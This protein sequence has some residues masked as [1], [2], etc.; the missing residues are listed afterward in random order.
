M[1][2]NDSLYTWVLTHG[3]DVGGTPEPPYY[4]DPV[5]KPPQVFRVQHLVIDIFQFIFLAW[6]GITR[7]VSANVQASVCDGSTASDTQESVTALQWVNGSEA[8]VQ[9]M[10]PLTA[11]AANPAC[12]C[13][14]LARAD[15]RSW[16]GDTPSGKVLDAS[17]SVF[18]TAVPGFRQYGPVAATASVDESLDFTGWVVGAILHIHIELDIG[19]KIVFH[20][21]GP[22]IQILWVA[23][24]TVVTLEDL[25][26]LRISGTDTPIIEF[27]SNPLLGLDDAAIQTLI[28]AQFQHDGDL[29]WLGGTIDITAIE[30]PIDVENFTIDSSLS[31][32]ASAECAL[33]VPGDYTY[34]GHVDGID[35]EHFQA[36]VTGPAMPQGDPNCANA[37]FN[38][39]GCVDQRDFA[40][41][42]RCFSGSVRLGDPDCLIGDP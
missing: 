9:D 31:A 11:T 14:S 8:V 35:L 19:E 13:W 12:G 26:I 5:P 30:L 22:V 25:W 37:D 10:D 38:K 18:A 16:F 7:R 28:L 29:W 4:P 1:S 34:D 17:A 33:L 27:W 42:Q 40:A 2:A 15:V 39:D 36:C 23:H 21:G 24:S 41:W 3:L 20:R 32:S 6:G